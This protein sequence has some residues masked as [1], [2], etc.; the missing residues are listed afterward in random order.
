MIESVIRE[1]GLDPEQNRLNTEGPAWGL[2]R[3][4]AEVFI[5][6]N[7][8]NEDER[9][10][11]LQCVSPVMKVPETSANQLALFQHILHLNASELTCAAFALKGDTVVLTADRSTL[12]LDASEVRDL[13]LNIGYY[14]DLYDDSLVNE[15]GGKRHTDAGS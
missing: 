9:G 15:F 11:H 8:G 4:S 6:V 5:F 14:A 1:L 10:N 7:P 2:A 13:V 12:D 3:G